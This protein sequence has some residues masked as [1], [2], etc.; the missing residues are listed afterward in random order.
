[1]DTLPSF[2]SFIEQKGIMKLNGI[3]FKTLKGIDGIWFANGA[4]ETTFYHTEYKGEGQ[5]GKMIVK[6]K[7]RIKNPLRD[8]II[9][10]ALPNVKEEV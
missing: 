9:E 7:T 10:N 3:L 8:A 2:E 5:I 6:F 4:T 1:M